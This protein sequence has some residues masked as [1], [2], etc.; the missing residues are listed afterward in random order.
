M[1][2]TLDPRR[3]RATLAALLAL[4]ALSPA[5]AGRLSDRLG[6]AL[7]G[8]S[9]AAHRLLERFR[10]DAE[11]Q[12]RLRRGR[13]LASLPTPEGDPQEFSWSNVQV[14]RARAALGEA[15]EARVGDD[16][17]A[18]PDSLDLPF[19]P[20]EGKAPEGI[21][22][23]LDMPRGL[24]YQ[25]WDLGLEQTSDVMVDMTIHTAPEGPAG[26]YL[27]V[28][29]AP[30][31]EWG[32]YMGLQFREE[33]GEVVTNAIWSRFGNEDGDD[34]EVADDGNGYSE[35]AGYEGEP[36]PDTGQPGGFISLRYRYD[37]GVGT[38]TFHVHLDRLD[39][40]GAWYRLRIYDHQQGEWTHIGRMRFPYAG[41]FE[42]PYYSGRGGSWQEV[43]TGV[44]TAREVPAAH[45]SLGGAYGLGRRVPAVSA[46]LSYADGN[47]DE[48]VPGIF[49]TDISRQPGGDRLHV[50]YG[51]ATRRRSEAQ[52]VFFDA[53]AGGGLGILGGGRASSAGLATQPRQGAMLGQ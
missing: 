2:G 22:D 3:A 53:G 25:S 34:L 28:W 51:G 27:Q 6:S 43:F 24:T 11:A 42:V 47:P 46:R 9:E 38:Y 49:N 15:G 39:F 5:R 23:Q 1:S 12:D 40:K 41:N 18:A 29:D 7:E 14:M 8:I 50:R 48:G 26:M 10:P 36:D 4:A 32:Q 30:L 44:D 45:V 21:D 35:V 52:T 37:F 13:F 19:D 17:R 20:D 16:F 31:G 33:D